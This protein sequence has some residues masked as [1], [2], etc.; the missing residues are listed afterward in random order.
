MQGGL[1]KRVSHALLK[2]LAGDRSLTQGLKG[3]ATYLI[4][5]ENRE[6]EKFGVN[7]ESLPVIVCEGTIRCNNGPISSRFGHDCN[8]VSARCTCWLAPGPDA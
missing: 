5:N 6:L 7:G 2:C 3:D 4:V 8:V 1:C